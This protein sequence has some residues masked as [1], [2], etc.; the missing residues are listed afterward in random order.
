MDINAILTM[1]TDFFKS[2]PWE[3][4]IG[5]FIGS[6]QGIDWDSLVGVFDFLD[7]S[8]GPIQD[9]IDAAIAF[10]SSLFGTVA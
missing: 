4:V 7:F 6:I 8:S 3:N 10:F 5:S 1:V 9:F 2:I